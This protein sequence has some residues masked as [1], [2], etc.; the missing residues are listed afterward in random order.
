MTVR[1]MKALTAI[2]TMMCSF[3]LV[4]FGHVSSASAQVG[5][6][7]W[8]VL[9]GG[10]SGAGAIQAEGYYP[11][12]IT[13]DAGDTV[14]WTLNT[15]EIHSVTFTGTC[16]D[17]SC[18]PSC[19]FTVVIDISPCGS[20]SFDG[21]SALD[22]SGRMV[23]PQYN[24]D[25]SFPHGSTTYSLTFTQPGVD[26]YFDLSVSGM[27]GVVIVNPAGTPYP[28]DQQQYAQ[29]GRDELRSDLLA[30]IAARHGFRPVARTTRPDGTHLYNVDLGASPPE[31]TRVDID[32]SAGSAVAGSAFLAGRGVGTSPSPSIDVTVKL[33]GLRPGSVH[34][35]QILPGTCGSPAPTTGLIFSQI[36]SPPE[37]TLSSI[38]A[39]P[40]GNGSS[41]IV[42]AEP[43]NSNGPGQLRIPGAGWYV[44][45]SDGANPDNGST[46]AACG[47][48]VF[49]NAAVL[50]DIPRDIHVNVGDTVVWTNNTIN[51]V[52][53]VTF[54]AGQS[55][56]QLP[57]WY[58]GNP[59]G[60]PAAYDGMSFL[61]SGPLYGADAGRNHSIAVTFTAPGV[62]P[63]VDV[64]DI[65]L[66]MHGKVIVG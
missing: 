21:V 58:F 63:Y 35:V 13:V 11:H 45:V 65:V 32:P 5:P 22:S 4:H 50:R 39:G 46:S 25:S 24:W 61:D 29:Q 55:L 36:F 40:D 43:P 1:G 7:T 16:E 56:P 37:F 44:N 28:F 34:A 54:L 41:T 52:H 31:Q 18:V 59:T 2:M 48:V 15:A 30:G 53:G 33:S 20:P 51:E 49:R 8:Q 27:R 12:V 6:A 26:V 60:N 3:A 17:L 14:N 64:G 38:T 9:V 42:L 23:P 19:V 10:Q 62:F 47:N 66:G 57:E